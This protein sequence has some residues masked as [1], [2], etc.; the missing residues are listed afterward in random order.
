MTDDKITWNGVKFPAGNP[1]IDRWGE[2]K[3]HLSVNVY[4]EREF[5]GNSTITLHRRTTDINVK[6]HINLLKLYKENKTHSI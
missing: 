1:D 5:S 2:H 6:Y 4:E 3:R